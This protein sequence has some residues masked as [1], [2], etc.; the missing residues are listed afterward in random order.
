M[1]D[2]YR[3]IGR[4]VVEFS[5]LVAVMR[6]LAAEYVMGGVNR[7]HLGHMLLGGTTAA[8][9]ADAFFGLCRL[10]AD[11]DPA[12]TKAASAVAKEVQEL[13]QRRNDITHGDWL[14]GMFSLQPGP[15]KILDPRLVRIRPG[16]VLGAR[17]EEDLAVEDI[18]ALTERVRSLTGVVDEFGKLALKLPVILEAVGQQVVSTGELRVGDVLTAVARKGKRTEVMRD[19][20]RAAEVQALNYAW[21]YGSSMRAKHDL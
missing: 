7:S 11:Y 3:A 4:Y 20:P 19:G 17:E 2:A 5:Q 8:V 6:G 18:D 12:E 21:P 13:I 16:R 1:D 15:T 14:V 10:E 9:I